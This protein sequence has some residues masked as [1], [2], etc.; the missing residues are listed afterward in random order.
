MNVAPGERRQKPSKATTVV[1]V[2][3]KPDSH[4]RVDSG[5]RGSLLIRRVPIRKNRTD[6]RAAQG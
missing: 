3:A 6:A 2:I 4:A 1:S 5:R